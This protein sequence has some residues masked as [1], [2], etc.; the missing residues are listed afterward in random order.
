M[1][2]LGL[3]LCLI[4]GVFGAIPVT[5]DMKT[6]GY[7]IK[8][9]HLNAYQ[10]QVVYYTDEGPGVVTEQSFVAGYNEDTIVRYYIDGEKKPTIEA[11]VLLM[12]GIGSSWDEASKDTPWGNKRFGHNAANGGLW[13]T[14]RIPFKK[15]LN[16][17][18]FSFL[19]NFNFV[20]FGNNKSP[21][22]I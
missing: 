15:S 3:L 12:H 18:I 13:N 2:F 11:R 6:F 16:V 19:Y 7:S 14:I 1:A 4:N 17:T 20:S 8:A 21:T 5:K 22:I 10:E 9:G